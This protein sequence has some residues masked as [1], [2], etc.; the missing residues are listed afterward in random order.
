MRP[1]AGPSRRRRPPRS[2]RTRRTAPGSGLRSWQATAA[3][4]R[5]VTFIDGFTSPFLGDTVAVNLGGNLRRRAGLTFGGGFWSGRAGPAGRTSSWSPAWSVFS[6]AWWTWLTSGPARTGPRSKSARR[7]ALC[8]NTP[9]SRWPAACGCGRGPGW[10]RP[11]CGSRP[12]PDPAGG[13]RR[14]APG[15]RAVPGSRAVPGDTANRAADR[16]ENVRSGRPGC[17]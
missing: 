12:T 8:R 13:G 16:A 14:A 9:F 10:N 1:E 4:T 2:R 6:S 15:N 17:V 7:R 5:G 3:Y 11:R